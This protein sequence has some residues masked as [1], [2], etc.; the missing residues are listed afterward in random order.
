[1]NEI[2]YFVIFINFKYK[3]KLKA[4]NNYTVSKSLPSSLR[5][6]SSGPLY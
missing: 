5:S 6:P 1:M 3:F 2:H 4:L